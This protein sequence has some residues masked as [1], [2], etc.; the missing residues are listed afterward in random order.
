MNLFCPN[1]AS[2]H[3]YLVTD[4]FLIEKSDGTEVKKVLHDNPDWIESLKVHLSDCKCYRC[5]FIEENQAFV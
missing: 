3:D 1:K 2:K 4:Y 5:W